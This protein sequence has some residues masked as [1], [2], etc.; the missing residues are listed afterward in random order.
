[1]VST[2]TGQSPRFYLLVLCDSS[3]LVL[4]RP[5]PLLGPN[6]FDRRFGGPAVHAVALFH[7][8]PISRPQASGR[9]GWATYLPWALPHLLSIIFFQPTKLFS[10]GQS[11][12]CFSPLAVWKNEAIALKHIVVAGLRWLM[13]TATD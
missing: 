13:K 3:I 6:D 5:R 9:W 4:G 7:A 1:M 11:I 8:L 12:A 10:P 2:T